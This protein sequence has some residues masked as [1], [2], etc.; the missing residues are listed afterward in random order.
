MLRALVAGAA[1]AIGTGLATAADAMPSY[2]VVGDG[3]PDPLAPGAADAAHGRALIVQ[4][5][6][7]NCVLCHAVPDPAVRFSGDVGPS[8]AG[9]GARLS[10]PQLRLRVS[11]NLRVNPATVMPS[12]YKVAGLDRVAAQYE[13][14]PVLS[15]QDVEDIVAYLA[16]LR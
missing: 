7:A 2:R 14:K 15:A 4:R 11:D 13:G 9:V 8:L 1:L 3:I 12:Y 6:A 16:T 10:A 5:D